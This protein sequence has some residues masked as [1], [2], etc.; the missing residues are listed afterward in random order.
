MS[1]YWFPRHPQRLSRSFHA[2]FWLIKIKRGVLMA[3]NAIEAHL[4]N[5]KQIKMLLVCG[6]LQSSGG[7]QLTFVEPQF[8]CENAWCTRV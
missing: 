4:S 2:A 3:L 8:V 1:P 5:L 6:F 7:A